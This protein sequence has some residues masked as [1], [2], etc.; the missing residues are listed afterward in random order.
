MNKKEEIK[1]WVIEKVKN[2]AKK[3]QVIFEDEIS[4]EFSLTGSGIFDSMDFMVLIADV[5]SAFNVIVDFSDSDPE[6]FTTLNGFIECI[7][8]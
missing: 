5:E 4:D 1:R 7:K 8:L 2:K 6:Q 3:L